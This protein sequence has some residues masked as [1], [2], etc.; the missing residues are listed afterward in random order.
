MEILGDYNLINQ[1]I[2]INLNKSSLSYKKG[3]N[4]IEL[5]YSTNI[6]TYKQNYK[7]INGPFYITTLILDSSF[8]T[9]NGTKIFIG[10]DNDDS[11][12]NIKYGMFSYN[13]INYLIKNIKTIFIYKIIQVS[14]DKIIKSNSIN[15]IIT[16]QQKT[17]DFILANSRFIAS[18]IKSSDVVGSYNLEYSDDENAFYSNSNKFK[19]S[20]VY[21]FKNKSTKIYYSYLNRGVFSY[22]T[23][24]PI[25]IDIK[26]MKFEFLGKNYKINGISEKI[27]YENL[28]KDTKEGSPSSNINVSIVN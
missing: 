12:K 3:E 5:L 20:L 18:T 21:E 1:Y 13:N 2:D 27:S 7:N 16:V 28:G 6:F 19:I 22:S 14:T 17:P 23:W 10:V 4:I 24:T 8:I 9:I 25:N 15:K 26:T 11:G